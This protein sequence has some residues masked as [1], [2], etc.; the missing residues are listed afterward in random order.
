[1]GII[2][3]AQVSFIVSL[4]GILFQN[5]FQILVILKPYVV[6]EPVMEKVLHAHEC[7]R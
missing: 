5:L 4:L 3:E 1:M 2:L 6:D 7:V